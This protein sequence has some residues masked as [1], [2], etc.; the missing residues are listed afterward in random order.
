MPIAPV[1]LFVS[2][3]AM[4]GKT[5][6]LW[7]FTAGLM[8]PASASSLLFAIFFFGLAHLP[9]NC[10]QFLQLSA[11][12]PQRIAVYIVMHEVSAFLPDE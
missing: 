11:K 5:Y 10:S 8:R 12:C 7:A 4:A 3:W 2:I 1:L 9:F 6:F